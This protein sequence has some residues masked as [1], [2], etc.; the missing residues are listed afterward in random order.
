MSRFIRGIFLIG[1]FWAAADPVVAEQLVDTSF[2]PIV[3]QPTYPQGTGPTV[4]IDA[5]HHNFHTAGGR[6]EPFARLLRADG[7]DVV[8][9]AEV[10]T[11][12][13]LKDCDLLVIANALAERNLDDWSLPTPSAFAQEETAS[14]ERWVHGGRAL[15]L[16]ADHMPF[17]GAAEDLARI[18]GV[19][20]INAYV[21]QAAGGEG[22]VVFSR[23]NGLL[24]GHSISD[25]GDEGERIGQVVSFTG[26]AFASADHIEPL[27]RLDGSVVAHLPRVAGEFSAWT[28]RRS[29]DGWLQGGVLRHGHGRVAVFAEAGMFTAQLSGANRRPMGMNAPEAKQNARFALNLMRWL[30][31][32]LRKTNR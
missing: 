31:Q 6:F 16:I 1:W 26:A 32:D 28:P 29:V 25:G 12:E 2:V 5:G 4:C 8:G 17:A 3:S 22:M 21:L 15:L 24:A 27:L 9:V 30:G 7:Y 11:D 19:E 13:S 23:D 10:F 14:V 20:L 18:F